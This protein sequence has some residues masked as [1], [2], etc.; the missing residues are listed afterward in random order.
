M[1]RLKATLIKKEN[2]MFT[3]YHG[4]KNVEETLRKVNKNEITTEF[5]L[6]YDRDTAELYGTVIAFEFEEDLTK[7]HHGKI[8]M[9]PTGLHNPLT[10]GLPETVLVTEMA[11]REFKM[12]LY[13]FYVA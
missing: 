6:S 12:N 13:D 1:E 3:Y 9:R 8:G 11:V 7:A 5:H 10:N 2:I 4:S